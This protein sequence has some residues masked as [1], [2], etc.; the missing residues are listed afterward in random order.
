MVQYGFGR[1]GNRQRQQF[2][3]AGPEQ[4]HNLLCPGYG[5][6]CRRYPASGQAAH[7][8]VS[9]YSGSNNTNTI[10]YFEV[11]DNCTL[12]SAKVYTDTPGERLVQVK[13]GG[14]E[15]ASALVNVPST[16]GL[17]DG[18]RITLNLALTPG[19]Y[20]LE[21]DAATNTANF[22]FS[23]PRL[24]RSNGGGVSY[25]YT[26]PGILSVTGCSEGPGL[27]YYFYDWEVEG[28][29]FS[30]VS[31]RSPAV[32][33]VWSDV[34]VQESPLGI[35]SVYPNPVSDLLYIKTEQALQGLQLRLIDVSGKT[36]RVRNNISTA[37][38]GTA[39]LSV[40]GAAPGI[41]TL[42]LIQDGT[43]SNHRIIIH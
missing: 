36:V 26:L 3:D 13:Q 27:F 33:T 21:T 9:P 14:T 40:S 8:G 30:C 6:L 22:G 37:A 42:Q 5:S 1:Y 24:Q 43:Q 15:V 20:T 39:T 4:Y 10:T 23:G 32:L 25:P 28:P 38:G 34:S 29:G 12:L 41:Y 16:S 31:A 11:Y 17:P 2:C 19:T 18:T 35:V 7:T